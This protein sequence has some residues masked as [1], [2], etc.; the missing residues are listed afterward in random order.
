VVWVLV[1]PFLVDVSSI[2]RQVLPSVLVVAAPTGLADTTVGWADPVVVLV[3]VALPDAV[4]P[5]RS[6]V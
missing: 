3:A 6:T 1:W 5:D 2:G 4:P